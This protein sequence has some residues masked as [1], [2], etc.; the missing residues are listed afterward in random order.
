MSWLDRL[1]EKNSANGTS[2]AVAKPPLAPLAPTPPA[3]NYGIFA[4][5]LPA[6]T[7][8]QAER[9]D[10]YGRVTCLRCSHLTRV[11][12][13]R[14]SPHFSP[15]SSTSRIRVEVWGMNLTGVYDRV[16]FG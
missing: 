7:D 5:R 8:A 2:G 11:G 14:A 12:V 15:P 10:A 13:C 3:G 16:D 6:V 4:G 9:E 1:K